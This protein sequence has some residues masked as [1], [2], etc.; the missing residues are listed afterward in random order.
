MIHFAPG[1]GR[2]LDGWPNRDLNLGAIVALAPDLSAVTPLLGVDEQAA[3]FPWPH[4][5]DLA[6]CATIR[7]S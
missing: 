6:A 2:R 3:R 1:V 7:T 4:A 5:R